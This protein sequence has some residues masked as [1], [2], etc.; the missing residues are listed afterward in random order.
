[1]KTFH[2]PVDLL[3]HGSIFIRITG[4]KPVKEYLLHKV[5]SKSFQDR[6]AATK[7]FVKYYY[8]YYYYYY[9][10]N[11]IAEKKVVIYIT[12]MYNVW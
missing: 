3:E 2:D 9:Y 1:M 10:V 4:K 12:G 8:Y 6:F 7:S 5:C 11:K